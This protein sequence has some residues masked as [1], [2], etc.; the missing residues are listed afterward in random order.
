MPLP[1]KSLVIDFTA[2]GKVKSLHFDSFPLSFLG[3]MEI[4]RATEIVFCANEQKWG[5]VIPYT[6]YCGNYMAQSGLPSYEK[7]R[8][9]E[10]AWLNECRKEQCKP[11]STEGKSILK[12]LREN[13]GF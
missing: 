4:E 12:T 3:D 2:S 11:C 13:S 1:S 10:V 5:I 9:L 6:S 7:A 8:E